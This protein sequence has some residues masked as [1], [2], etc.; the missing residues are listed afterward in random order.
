M[1]IEGLKLMVLG[2]TIVV[3]F[4]ALL[5][6]IVYLLGLFLKSSTQAE[7][8]SKIKQVNQVPAIKPEK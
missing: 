6:F 3:V 1:V 4:L 5:F 2:M 7:L 8:T